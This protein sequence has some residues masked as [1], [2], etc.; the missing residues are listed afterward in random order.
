MNY[1]RFTYQNNVSPVFCNDCRALFSSR[2]H[3]TDT[4]GQHTNPLTSAPGTAPRALTAVSHGFHND[5]FMGA[6]CAC[7]A[8]R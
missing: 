6:Y 3:D 7:E 4:C 1:T 5:T 8:C 2:F